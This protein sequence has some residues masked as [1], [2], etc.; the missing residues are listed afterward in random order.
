LMTSTTARVIKDENPRV[1]MSFLPRANIANI[2]VKRLFRGKHKCIITEQNYNSI[3]YS[4]NLAGRVFMRLMQITYPQADLVITNARGLAEDVHRN[5][6]VPEWKL[7]VIYSPFDLE[8]IDRLSRDEVDHPWFH[9]NIPV[10]IHAARLIE[11]KNQQLLL[12]AF[13]IVKKKIPC[14]LVIFG[15]GPLENLLKETA[16]SLGISDDVDFLGWHDNI[17]KFMRRAAA[18][19][20]TSNYEGLPSVLIQAMACGCP[21]VSTDCPSGPREILKDGRYGLLAP[22]GDVDALSKHILDILGDDKLRDSLS[23][24]GKERARDFEIKII[25]EEYREVIQDVVVRIGDLI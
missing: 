2:L 22:V 14:R 6:G 10:L 11:Q 20:L 3:Q 25:S 4:H 17:F 8:M 18:F 16:Y 21:V 19:I 23:L 7:K 5:F 9:D 15:E 24:L 1:V 12:K 13:A